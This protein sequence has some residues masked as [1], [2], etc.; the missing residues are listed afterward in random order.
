MYFQ[1]QSP[2]QNFSNFNSILQRIASAYEVDISLVSETL[3]P[4]RGCQYHFELP[5][6]VDTSQEY[7]ADLSG[8]LIRC[9]FCF[10]LF[11]VLHF[12]YCLIP[13]S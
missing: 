10:L 9:V 2:C 3:A 5:L 11:L 12:A 7:Y 1:F 6:M 4:P 13:S 8:L